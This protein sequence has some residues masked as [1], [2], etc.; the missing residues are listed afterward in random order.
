MLTRR[1]QLL[2]LL[3]I[4]CPPLPV[5]LKR[6]FSFDFLLSIIL[7]LAMY[8][9]GLIFGWYI[10]STYEE[11]PLHDLESAP[12]DIQE[13]MR[14]DSQVFAMPPMEEITL[15]SPTKPHDTVNVLARFR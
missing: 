10:V 15:P 7:T 12:E 9:P 1:D 4:L 3:A 13:R 6:G 14:K 8:L 2:L 11:D 5:Y